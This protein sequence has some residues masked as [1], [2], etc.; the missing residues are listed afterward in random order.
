ME[1]DIKKLALLAR[2]KL[3][4]GE[5]KK[6]QK[7]FEGIL[8]YISKL[9]EVNIESIDDKEAVKT[10]T[11]ENVMRDDD[12]YSNEPGEFS[13]KLLKEAPETERGYVKVKG[14]FSK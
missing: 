13:E 14:V 2:I 6:F 12:E 11:L 9:K 7:E 4:E 8:V 1:I 5:E 3:E 10:N